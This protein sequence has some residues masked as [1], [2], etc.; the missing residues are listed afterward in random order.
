MR[1]RQLI[2]LLVVLS[3]GAVVMFLLAP[4]ARQSAPVQAPIAPIVATPELE[5]KSTMDAREVEEPLGAAAEV[6]KASAPMKQDLGERGVPGPSKKRRGGSGVKDS[7]FLTPA[8]PRLA[9]ERGEV[10]EKRAKRE[11]AER[12]HKSVDG[13]LEILAEDSAPPRRAERDRAEKRPSV[14]TPKAGVSKASEN[15]AP[16]IV[17]VPDVFDGFENQVRETEASV[18]AT[19]IETRVDPMSTFSVD[20]DTGGY[21][22]ARARLRAGYRPKPQ[23]VRIE[24]FL[25]YF[26]YDYP[27]PV[28]GEFSVHLEAA[29][30]PLEAASNR[31]LIR[32]GVKGKS[33][34][35]DARP[36]AHLTFLVDVSGSMFGPDRLGLV[37]EA[38]DLVTRNLRQD[39]TIAI[40][41][42][43]RGAQVRLWPAGASERDL[44]SGAI[45]KLEAGG[46]S[47]LDEGLKLAYEVASTHFYAGHI[48][49]VI[50]LGDGRA[51]VG[52][53]RPDVLLASIRAGVEDGVMLSTIGLG[54][55][56]FND[57]MMERLADRGNGSYFFVDSY[58][59]AQKVFGDRLC[60]TLYAIAEDVKI[61]VEFDPQSVLRHRLL[62]YENRKLDHVQFRDDKVDAAEVGAGHAVTAIYEVELSPTLGTTLATVHVRYKQPGSPRATETTY[63]LFSEELRASVR[64]A[65]ADFKFAAAV[66][67]FAEIARGD[68]RGGADRLSLVR[69]I[70]SESAMD[71]SA[72]PDRREFIALLAEA[73]P[74]YQR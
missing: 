68:E 14:R 45:A 9:D 57:Q 25:N 15:A 70:A 34:P 27:E 49:R 71:E 40:V 69:E 73:A 54:A 21:T 35:N 23:D 46:S 12:P 55:K 3:C 36:P 11:R 48:N 30:D 17:E 39:D 47:A 42:Y 63:T 52:E 38:L 29:P 4:G 58:R 2:G 31:H 19:M 50:L 67:M 13:R 6:G 7:S 8:V 72:H 20:V 65:S 1:K 62:G 32:I 64:E 53:T 60:G 41:T 26:Q 61:Q 74:Y 37:I 28:D 22:L 59:E 33:V 56:S 43:A 18:S 44:A 51:N 24:E 10:Q 66:A 16:A 5:G